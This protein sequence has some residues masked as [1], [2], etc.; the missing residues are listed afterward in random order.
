MSK[1]DSR[2]Y[3]PLPSRFY[4][5]FYMGFAV[6]LASKAADIGEVPVG[7]VV[8]H[9]T[10][11]IVG[12]GINRREILKNALCHAEIESIDAACRT[13]G[14]WRLFECDLYVTLEP[15]PM[16]AGAIVNARIRRVV[17]GA[18][19]PK[20]GACL[21]VMN[22]FDMPFN[23]KPYLEPYVL[24]DICSAQLSEFF[25]RLRKSRKRRRKFIPAE[26]KE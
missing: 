15:C 8:V 18:Y 20:G 17:F 6:Y 23:H 11:G 14:G 12:V 13:L 24:G 1:V 25:K 19:D 2:T 16:C 10:K 22:M 5:E 21:S 9:R 7:A 26:P 3:L 4:D